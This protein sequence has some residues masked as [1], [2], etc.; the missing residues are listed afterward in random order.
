[1]SIYYFDTQIGDDCNSGTSPECAFKSLKPAGKLVLHPGD[2]IL[3]ARG[4]RFEDQFL[5]LTARGTRENPIVIGAYGEGDRPLIAANGNGLWYQNYQTELDNPNHVWHGYV[6]SAVLLYDCEYI[7]LKEIEITND[8]GLLLGERYNQPDKMN[9]TGVAVVA[10]NCGTLHEITL[11]DLYVHHVMGNVYDKHLN[12]GGI[13]CTCLKPE[14]EDTGVARYDGLR[15]TQ[16]KVE[17]CSRW[18]IAAGY[19]YTHT[20]FTGLYLDEDEVRTY[21]H[22]NVYIADCYVK[23]IGGDGI[24]PMYC[25]RP[26]IERN[27]AENNAAE[28]ND[29]VYT[30][31]GTRL[32]KTAAA[33]WPWKC[34]DALFQYNEAYHTCYN[35]DGQAWDADSGDGTVYQYNYSYHNGGGCVMFCLGE[36]VNNIFRYNISLFDGDGIMNP[37]ENPDAHIYGNTFILAPGVP[38]IRNNMSGGCMLVENNIIMNT[39][40]EPV[41][42]DWYHQTEHAVYKGN[43]YY[44]FLDYPAED[45]AA[46]ILPKDAPLLRNPYSGPRDTDGTVHL[47]SAFEGFV[48]AADFGMTGEEIPELKDF[49]GKTVLANQIGA[50]RK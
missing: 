18:G 7:C 4:S 14:K 41:A 23:D 49:L 28:I 20:H 50:C 19:S 1:M 42:G 33:I 40:E 46:V 3:L 11:T 16:C 38:F 26:L 31:A 45:E 36:S 48:P 8:P 29:S 27:V 44:N 21:G 13:Y 9:R 43:L 47:R 5:H 6:S 15:I 24:T 17:K 22:E 2:Q 34:K 32:G 35:Q 10:Q 37:A 30:E 12:N 25:Y 39:A